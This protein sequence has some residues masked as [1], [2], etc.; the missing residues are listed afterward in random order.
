MSLLLKLGFRT[1]AR[2]FRFVLVNLLGLAVAMAAT[3]MIGLFVLHE[4]DYDRWI[5]GADELY[6]ATTTWHLAGRAPSTLAS[7][8]NPLKAL[9]EK[10][11]PEVLAVTRL[12]SRQQSVRTEG[13]APRFERIAFV[14][15]N[16]FNLFDL[17]ARAGSP[18]AALR[19]LRSLVL[20]ERAA[21][22][23]FG[24]PDAMGRAIRVTIAGKE[25]TYR[26]GAVLKD[27]PSNT[28]LSSEILAR[29]E[30]TDFLPGER[31]TFN[32]WGSAN[33]LL[34]FRLA[35]DTDLAGF[36]DRVNEG[37]AEG[38]REQ[39][40]DEKDFSLAI[41]FMPLPSLHLAAKELRNLGPKT[42]GD[43]VLL[44]ALSLIAVLI[45]VMAVVNYVNLATAIA[46]RRTR[47]VALKR[48]FGA[49][50][51]GLV[52]G[53]FAESMMVAALAGLLALGIVEMALPRLGDLLGIDLATVSVRSLRGLVLTAA[54]ILLTGF[55]AGI[56]P[57]LLMARFR[58]VHLFADASTAGGRDARLLRTGFVVLQF[59]ASTGL[60]A[61]TMVIFAQ[62][63]HLQQAN[64]RYDPEGLVVVRNISLEQVEES[65]QTLIERFAALPGVTAVAMS[66]NAPGADDSWNSEPLLYRTGGQPAVSINRVEVD[67]GF[68]ETVGTRPVAGRLL[69]R[70]IAG[71]DDYTKFGPEGPANILLNEAAVRSFGF[72]SPQAAIGEELRF[73][74]NE[75][76][77]NVPAHIVGVVPNLR[78]GALREPPR[79]TFYLH[80]SWSFNLATIRY[81]GITPDEAMARIEGAWREVAPDV[82][83]S[84]SHVDERLIEFTAPERTQASLL[85]AFAA[86]AVALA[87]VGIYG[88]AAFTAQRRAREMAVRRVFG[89]STARLLERILGR[90][91]GLVAIGGAIG[92]PVAFVIDARWLE[93]Y[94]E[95]IAHGPAPYLLALA[96]AALV[97]LGSVAVEAWRVARIAPAEVLR[98]E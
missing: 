36:E 28:H 51:G 86:L 16:F 8:P 76:T 9:A 57:A 81:R 66:S 61:A 89:A 22:E 38:L 48:I 33:L 69:A 7:G 79:P 88:I 19:D 37:V 25:F 52:R 30:E 68:F 56:W 93:H 14:D 94:P 95:R 12:M 18:G 71:D 41:S 92:V 11:H 84:A 5:P 6:L 85:G 27:L 54:L 17:P 44:L 87:A 59:A 43:P 39:F 78:F 80:G 1:L 50:R 20:T 74:R 47:E 21:T 23:L 26:V 15:A 29:L 97:A 70:E 82:P 67:F 24:T 49:S 83:F 58:P 55:A 75:G 34:Y 46:M 3:F 45:L 60:I 72:E 77:N 31:F 96:L 2:N 35:P 64:L 62:S 63:R 65:K 90:F 53:Y 73:S 4:T 32:N 42:S 13:E 40:G 98:Q 10:S 91:L